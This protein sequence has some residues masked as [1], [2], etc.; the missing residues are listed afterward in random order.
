MQGQ[1]HKIIFMSSEFVLIFNV[2]LY[3]F[4]SWY[5]ILRFLPTQLIVDADCVSQLHRSRCTGNSVVLTAFMLN[6]L[7]PD[8]VRTFT[9][10]FLSDG[11]GRPRLSS[12]LSTLMTEEAL[13]IS[14][15]DRLVFD[16]R[17]SR[18]LSSSLKNKEWKAKLLHPASC[19]M[20]VDL[21]TYHVIKWMM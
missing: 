9:T 7:I 6:L 1:H 21:V 15:G 11:L 17:L 2:F 16:L 14:H 5:D 20:N 13:W 4:N 18:I 10:M 19:Q 12:R 3:N 8:L